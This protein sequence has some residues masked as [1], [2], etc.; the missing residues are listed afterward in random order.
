[1]P[2]VDTTGAASHVLFVGGVLLVYYGCTGWQLSEPVSNL[3]LCFWTSVSTVSQQVQ[4]DESVSV[5]V[6]S[7]QVT[8]Q[9]S[10]CKLSVGKKN[11]KSCVLI[12]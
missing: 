6:N 1:M 7:D 3:C 8:V 11:V 2:L 12:C 5:C 9:S 4:S 10:R